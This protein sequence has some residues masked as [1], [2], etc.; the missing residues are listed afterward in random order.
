MPIPSSDRQ[1]AYPTAHVRLGTPAGPLWADRPSY[2]T[3]RS[4]YVIWLDIWL[5]GGLGAVRT[6][7]LTRNPIGSL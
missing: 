1:D 3:D 7:N 2:A 4:G 6:T 5:D